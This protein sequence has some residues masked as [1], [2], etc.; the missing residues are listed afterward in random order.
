ML[1]IYCISLYNDPLVDKHIQLARTGLDEC[2]FGER[3]EEAVALKACHRYV[4]NITNGGS[5]GV[6]T[7]KAAGR[8]SQSNG[9]IGVIR[10]ELELT[11]Y[12]R[13]LLSII[14]SRS[15]RATT[16]NSFVVGY[17]MPEGC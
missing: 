12:G 15:G 11:N 7:Y 13:Q 8:Y 9:G 6:V 14:K 10:E 4:M 17:C 1:E 2:F 5:A 16:T 3:Y